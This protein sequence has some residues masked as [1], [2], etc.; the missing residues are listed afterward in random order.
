LLKDLLVQS[1][2]QKTY[3]LV[4]RQ[5]TSI[6][7][8]QLNGCTSIL[9]IGC[10]CGSPASPFQ[11]GVYSVGV[12]LFLPSLKKCKSKHIYTDVVYGDLRAIKFKPKS[13]DCVISTDVI[14]HFNKKDSL[15]LIKKMEAIAIKKVII[16]TP[17]G[18]NP[19]D[20][21]EDANPLQVHKSGWNVK[22]FREMGYR[23]K[24]SDGLK[25]LRGEREKLKYKPWVLWQAVSDLTQLLTLRLPEFA[26]S[27][28]CIR[29]LSRVH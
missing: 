21:L 6:I 15:D 7:R 9:D 29:E 2:L 3:T 22:E 24:G 10:G 12:E 17:N 25:Q 1:P 26:F 4:F 13:F 8:E 11:K 5:Y 28:I 23:V 16:F 14:E 19:K 18:Y 27:I 20:F